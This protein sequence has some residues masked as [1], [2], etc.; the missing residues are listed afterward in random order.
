[1]KATNGSQM[2]TGCDVRSDFSFDI[3]SY[4]D[5]QLFIDV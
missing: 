5:N 4:M 2:A 1:M 3:E